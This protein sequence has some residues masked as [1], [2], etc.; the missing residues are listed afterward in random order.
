MNGPRRRYSTDY[1][2]FISSLSLK[3]NTLSA[4]SVYQDRLG[5]RKRFVDPDRSLALEQLTYNVQRNDH[6]NTKS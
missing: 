1:C 4:L 3:G 6:P 5:Q 2:T